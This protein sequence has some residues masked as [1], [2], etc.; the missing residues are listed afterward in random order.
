L[1]NTFKNRPDVTRHDDFNGNS[2]DCW[3]VDSQEAIDWLSEKCDNCPAC[4]LAVLKQ[5][6]VLAFDVFDYKERASEYLIQKNRDHRE[7][8]GL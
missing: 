8:V 6:K 1:V 3:G 2:I 7:G 5:G 4:M